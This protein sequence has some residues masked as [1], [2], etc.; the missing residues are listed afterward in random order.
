MSEPA[1]PTVS[2][3]ADLLTRACQLLGE[4][5]AKHSARVYVELLACKAEQ[6]NATPV[7]AA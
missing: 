6:T 5:P 3:P 7:T 4:L 2:V 1:V